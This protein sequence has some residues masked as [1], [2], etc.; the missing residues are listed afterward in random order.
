VVFSLNRKE[1]KRTKKYLEQLVKQFPEIKF[2]I[3]SKRKDIKID[4]SLILSTKDKNWDWQVL[5]E[6]E[7]AEISNELILELKDKNWN[8]QA[9]SKR[10]NIE[11]SNETLLQL[12]DKDWDWNYLSENTNLD[13][14]LNSLRKQKQNLGTGNL[15]HNTNRLCQQFEY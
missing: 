10:K 7:R 15:F 8:W 13:L 14:T 3:L 5:S 12:L 4:S 6:N 2:D 1:I 11:F 9:L